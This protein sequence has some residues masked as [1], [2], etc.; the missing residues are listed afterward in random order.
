LSSTQQ[1]QSRSPG[2]IIFVT[3]TFKQLSGSQQQF[4]NSPLDTNDLIKM[5]GGSPLIMKLLEGTQGKESFSPKQKKA[6]KVLCLQGVNANIL[7]QEFI[8]KRMVK[9][10]VVL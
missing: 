9:T 2:Q 1:Q 6:A 10:F 7:V 4:A 8:K 3:T 5:V